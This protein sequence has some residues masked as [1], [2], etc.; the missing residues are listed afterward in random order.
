MRIPLFKS[1]SEKDAY[2]AGIDCAKNG[3][4]TANC[5]FSLFVTPELMKAWE[6]GK[7]SVAGKRGRP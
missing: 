1:R 5:H 2:Q 3:A 6:R 4:T 7:K